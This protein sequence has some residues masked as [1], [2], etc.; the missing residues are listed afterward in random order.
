MSGNSIYLTSLSGNSVNLTSTIDISGYLISVSGNPVYILDVPSFPTSTVHV[1]RVKLTHDIPM[2]ALSGGGG[3]VPTH[4]QPG[5]R[6]R[7][8]VSTKL[9]PLYSRR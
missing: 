4:S 7:L 5:N 1:I 6:R 3:I 8:K 2:Q 9:Q